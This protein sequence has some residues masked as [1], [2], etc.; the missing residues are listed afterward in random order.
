RARRRAY[1]DPHHRPGVAGCC[2]GP[3]LV[4]A[5]LGQGPRDLAAV[6]ALTARSRQER[7]MTIDRRDF[8]GKAGR[9]ARGA[10]AVTATGPLA[11]PA[12]A[13]A[14]PAHDVSWLIYQAPGGSI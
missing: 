2:V 1:P 5:C 12:Q 4:S 7:I 14:F 3:F 6:G 10:A 8:L 11:S 13:Q 9:T